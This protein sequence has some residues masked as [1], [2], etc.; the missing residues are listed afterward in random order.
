MP[1]VGC[2]CIFGIELAFPWVCTRCQTWVC[3]LYKEDG[4][5]LQNRCSIITSFRFIQVVFS[6]GSFVTASFSLFF[7]SFFEVLLLS[8]AQFNLVFKAFLEPFVVATFCFIFKSIASVILDGYLLS[9]S[10]SAAFLTSFF[11]VLHAMHHLNH[12][13][14][15]LLNHGA[16][17]H[18]DARQR[19]RSRAVFC[20]LSYRLSN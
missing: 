14:M 6:R 1:F 8:L 3:Y 10:L 11:L 7:K 2:I 19:N 18:N 20:T 17:R 9:I 13:A 15:H 12:V 5:S 16:N 4:I